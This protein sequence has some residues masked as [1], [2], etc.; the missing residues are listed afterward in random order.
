M[1][2]K[3]DLDP[4]SEWF[5]WLFPFA[6]CLWRQSH[7]LLQLASEKACWNDLCSLWSQAQW[8]CSVPRQKPLKLSPLQHYQGGVQPSFCLYWAQQRSWGQM[9]PRPIL[10]PA[11]WWHL[12]PSKQAS[13]K[14][15]HLSIPGPNGDLHLGSVLKAFAAEGTHL[16]EQHQPICLYASIWP[17]FKSSHFCLG[18]TYIHQLC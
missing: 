17:T 16:S 9:E 6:F 7:C 8:V 2:V 5:C 10:E 11:S 13:S 12:S 3:E 1:Q 4:C 15:A 18:S 14:N